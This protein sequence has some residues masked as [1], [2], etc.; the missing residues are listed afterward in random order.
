MKTTITAK[1]VQQFNKMRTALLTI[2]KDYQTPAQLRKGSENQY[3]LD[4]GEA[5]EM[6]YENIQATAKGAVKG[7]REIKL[8]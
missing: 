4:Y 1:Q 5:I 7:I 6:S 8:K 2:S 3:G